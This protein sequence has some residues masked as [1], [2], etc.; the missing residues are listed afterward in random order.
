MPMTHDITRY[1][2]TAGALECGEMYVTVPPAFLKL[3]GPV[4]APFHCITGAAA[5]PSASTVG[6]GRKQPSSCFYVFFLTYVIPMYDVI[7][8]LS[9]T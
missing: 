7:A 8:R 6:V 3:R 4:G 2:L 9:D 1:H 5:S